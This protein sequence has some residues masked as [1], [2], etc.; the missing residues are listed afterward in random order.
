MALV[1][2]DYLI[3]IVHHCKS[4]VNMCDTTRLAG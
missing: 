2:E 4:D 1:G 3:H